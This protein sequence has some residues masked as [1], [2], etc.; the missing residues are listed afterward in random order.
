MTKFEEFLVDKGYIMYAFDF[1]ENKFYKPKVHIISTMT[2][3][4]HF[5]IH[6]SDTDLLKRIEKEEN[7]NNFSLKDFEKTI[8]YGLSE[9]DK[10]STL[11]SPRPRIL[12]KRFRTYNEQQYKVIE[13]EKNDDSMN[14]VISKINFEDIY[15]AMY[16]K[17]IVFKFDL[18]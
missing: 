14:I 4:R 15:K 16:D 1:K 17:S 13:S 10:P 9:K 7:P 3:I 6:N 8:I 12:V 5:Y 11:I 2:N 18:T